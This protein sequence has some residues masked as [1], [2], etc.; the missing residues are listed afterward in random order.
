LN[1]PQ[2]AYFGWHKDT[3]MVAPIVI[4]ITRLSPHRREQP[5]TVAGETPRDDT[6]APVPGPVAVGVPPQL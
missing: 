3:T 4:E 5:A 2:T 1:P 6:T